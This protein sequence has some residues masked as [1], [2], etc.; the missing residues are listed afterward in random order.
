[1]DRQFSFWHTKSK[2]CKGFLTI[3]SDQMTFPQVLT[4]LQAAGIASERAAVVVLCGVI[5]SRGTNFVSSDFTMSLTHMYL[6][7]S[8]STD[9]SE[10]IQALRLLGVKPYD[11]TKFRP[12]VT[13]KL[14]TMQNISATMYVQECA[15]D[16]LKN[17]GCRSLH[18]A[19][20]TVVVPERPHVKYAPSVGVNAVPEGHSCWK[21]VG[22]FHPP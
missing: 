3:K 10:S 2:T 17:G 20:G 1:M 9:G 19:L 8:K 13:T 15:V 11:I 12:V 6:L 18:D 4:M 22:D 5:A 21:R 7:L 14:S 16:R